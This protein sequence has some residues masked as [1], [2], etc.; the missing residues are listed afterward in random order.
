MVVPPR[1]LDGTNAAAV[2]VL[3]VGHAT[4]ACPPGRRGPSS[5]TASAGRH[6]LHDCCL[7]RGRPEAAFSKESCMPNRAA[8]GAAPLL[9]SACCLARADPVCVTQVPAV[10]VDA[11]QRRQRG[12]RPAAGGCGADAGAAA[13]CRGILPKTL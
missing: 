3:Q 2:R 12:A 11:Q 13:A 7:P 8:S 1:A 10:P 4:S 9:R 6:L 5:A